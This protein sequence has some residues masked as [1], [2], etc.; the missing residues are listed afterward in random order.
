M[1]CKTSK[2][3]F[4]L[5]LAAIGPATAGE[6]VPFKGTFAGQTHSAVPTDDPDVLLVTTG[7]GGHATHLGKDRLVAPHL[8]NLATGGVTGT[9]YFT[10][11]N[12]DRLTADFTGQ[13]VPTP[14]GLLV[15]HLSCSITGGTGRFEGA[16]GTYAF[17]VVFDPAT[18]Q[19][20]ARIEGTI[21]F[22]HD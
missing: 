18:F 1:L 7:G 9:H 19:S 15:G 13:F 21:S 2:A 4:F 22:S 14:D 16:T 10:A 8:A 3:A 5:L 11:A 12:G 20:V 17:V 6:P